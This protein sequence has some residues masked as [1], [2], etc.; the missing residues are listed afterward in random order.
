MRGDEL[1]LEALV[2]RVQ[3]AALLGGLQIPE[4]GSMAKAQ[5]PAKGANN[6]CGPN[7]GRKTH[8]P[9]NCF[10]PMSR[11]LA[12]MGKMP[13]VSG[14]STSTCCFAP[15]KKENIC[16]VAKSLPFKTKRGCFVNKTQIETSL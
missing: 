14:D 10:F 4:I 13:S 12:A 8:A 3:S 2:L 16:P 1:I 5:K 6:R 9:N 11:I 15:E 7:L